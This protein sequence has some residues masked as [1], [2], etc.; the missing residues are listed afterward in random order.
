MEAK[1]RSRLRIQTQVER[2]VKVLRTGRNIPKKGDRFCILVS[3]KS[4][5]EI[6]AGV[7]ILMDVAL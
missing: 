6:E 7:N 1:L 2:G 5:K 4:C 3:L